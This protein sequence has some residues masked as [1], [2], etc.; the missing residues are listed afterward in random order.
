MLTSGFQIKSMFG[1]VL[2]QLDE[3]Y[4]VGPP[5]FGQLSFRDMTYQ[6]VQKNTSV[7]GPGPLF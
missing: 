3:D 2:A 6:V 4:M 7:P 5:V 1:E